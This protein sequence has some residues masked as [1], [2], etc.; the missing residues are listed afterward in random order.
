MQLMH[1]K[2]TASTYTIN[3]MASDP[4]SSSTLGSRLS[5]TGMKKKTQFLTT[6]KELVTDSEDLY[7]SQA[8]LLRKD[9]KGL[10]I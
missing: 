7:K 5:S 3:S 2:R 8:F 4:E 1:K 6:K 9:C 10:Q